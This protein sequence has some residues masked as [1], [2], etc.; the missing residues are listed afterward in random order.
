[1]LPFCL[2]NFKFI[3]VKKK[4]TNMK[5]LDF[6]R[7]KDSINPFIPVLRDPSFCILVNENS[8]TKELILNLKGEFPYMNCPDVE[9]YEEEAYKNYEIICNFLL[10]ENKELLRDRWGL[11]FNEYDK[12][13]FELKKVLIENHSFYDWFK[14]KLLVALEFL[15][16][17]TGR[18]GI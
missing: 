6:Y 10:G 18:I 1:M 4:M 3:G 16:F 15:K 9:S 2:L 13:I 11:T 12:F 14:K 5:V 8:R 17:C 7:K